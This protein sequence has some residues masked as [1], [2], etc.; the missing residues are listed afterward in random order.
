MRSSALGYKQILF[1]RC[2]VYPRHFSKQ[3]C[4]NSKSCYN[5]ELRPCWLIMFSLRSVVLALG[6]SFLVAFR[7]HE[8]RSFLGI[9]ADNTWKGEDKI[10][11]KTHFLILYQQ[12]V[13]FLLLL[14]TDS[15]QP[16]IIFVSQTYYLS[17]WTGRFHMSAYLPD[18]W[19]VFCSMAINKQTNKWM[20]SPMHLVV[21]LPLLI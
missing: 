6:P 8:M 11:L 16:Y 9:S 18:S 13:Y 15:L 1:F 2:H 4:G 3:M 21:L 10:I 19:P 14:F 5:L 20:K 12:E 17:P 7:D